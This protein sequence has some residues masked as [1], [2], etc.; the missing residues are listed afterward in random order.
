MQNYTNYR[1]VYIDDASTDKTGE[2]VKSYILSRNIP[3]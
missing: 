3:L 2:Y 1:V